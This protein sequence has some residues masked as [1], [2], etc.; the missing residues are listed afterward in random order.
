[1]GGYFSGFKGIRKVNTYEVISLNVNSLGL[2]RLSTFD[3]TITWNNGDSIGVI[4]TVQDVIILS[5]FNS[6]GGLKRD[7][8]YGVR[9]VYT[10]CNYGGERPWFICPHC[11]KKVGRLYLKEGYFRCRTCQNLNYEIQQEDKSDRSI[12]SLDNKIFKI[13]KK[14]NTNQNVNNVLNIPKPKG[15]HYSTYESLLYRL[16][17]L[18]LQREKLFWSSV[19]KAFTRLKL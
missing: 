19:E 8:M 15:M 1:M 3:K 18:Y 16:R 12:K 4:K 13:Q 5:Y 7:Y 10:G 14:L 9:I 2:N 17:Q 6:Y 11:N